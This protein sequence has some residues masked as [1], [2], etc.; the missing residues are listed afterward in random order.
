MKKIFTLLC[1]MAL[2]AQCSLVSA[3]T[4]TTMDVWK[5]GYIIKSYKITNVDSVTFG[6]G[7][8]LINGQRFV[9]LGLPSGLLWAESN[10]GATCTVEDGY[11][12]AWG[13]T[14]TITKSSYTWDTYKFGKPDVAKGFKKYDPSDNKTTLEE[15]D[16][17]AYVNWG[18]PC[19]MPTKEEFA[20]LRDSSNCTWTWTGMLTPSGSSIKGYKVTSVRNGNWIFFPVSGYYKEGK[21]YAHGVVGRYWSSSLNYSEY[22]EIELVT[23]YAAYNELFSNDENEQQSYERYNGCSVRAVAKP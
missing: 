11:Y 1:C 21:L 13:E 5:N 14:D 17:A 12:F 22:H 6:K 9:D 18:Y 15:T 3:Q 23:C 4:T 7:V 8:H 20:E 2:A 10:V 16:D 19:R